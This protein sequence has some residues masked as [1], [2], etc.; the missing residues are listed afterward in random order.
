MRRTLY[1]L[2]LP[3]RRITAAQC[4][5]PAGRD[6]AAGNPGAGAAAGLGGKIIRFCM[7]NDGFAQNFT[8]GEPIGETDKQRPAAAAEQGRQIP[9]VIRMLRAGGVLMPQRIG[10]GVIPRTATAGAAVDMESKNWAPGLAGHGGWQPC[11]LC[12]DKNSGLSL[13]KR[14]PSP[15]FRIVLAASDYGGGLGLAVQECQQLLWVRIKQWTSS[16]PYDVPCHAMSKKG[17]KSGSVGRDKTGI[18]NFCKNCFL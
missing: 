13:I 15:D 4:S 9:G 5:P 2:T 17:G 1:R 14:D 12:R 8:Y 7:D 16:F 18:V 3:E 10:K 11:Q 6:H